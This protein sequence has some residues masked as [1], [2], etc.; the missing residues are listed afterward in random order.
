MTYFWFAPGLS[1][2][3][4]IA[5][6]RSELKGDAGGQGGTWALTQREAKHSEAV[7]Q[8]RIAGEHSMSEITIT[9]AALD[10]MTMI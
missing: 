5:D 1:H 6:F 3:T 2:S 10:C 8:A 7:Y 9:E 4:G